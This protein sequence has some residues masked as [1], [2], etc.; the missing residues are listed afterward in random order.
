MS[1][2]ALIL[3]ATGRT[4]R[5]AAA[6][7]SA[8]GWAVTPYRRG[9]VPLA[10]A[11]Q[12]AELIFNGWNPPYSQWAK[13]V[14]GL[15]AQ[16][17]DAARRSGAAVMI[18]GNVYGFGRDMPEALTPET[19]HAATHPLGRIRAEMEAAY[20]DAG[21]RT[22]VLRAGDFLDTGAS[23]NWFDRIIAAKVRRGRLSY[24][25]PV[26]RVHG[27]AYLPD[28]ASA[29]AGL[30]ERLDQLPDFTELTFPGYALTGEELAAACEAALG[31][32]LTLRRMSWSPV[33]L[34]RPFWA[35]A[36]HLLEMRYLWERPHR[37]DGTA[38]DRL[39]PDRP[40]TSPTDAMRAALAD[41][42]G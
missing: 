18:P 15:T 38:L 21:V 11:A 1:R 42:V 41:L 23:G 6:A 9:G 34:A 30:A 29:F 2:K 36:K 20:R 19:P 22:V 13:T 31:R 39:L 40:R 27:W 5:H 32:S 16:V 28:L 37:L 8:R 14:P 33:Q 26:D 3:G 10:E 24:P 17:I 12:D 25:G 4:G 35:E 7:L